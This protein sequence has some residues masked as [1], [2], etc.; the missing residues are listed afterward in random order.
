MIANLDSENITI[1]MSAPN[2][3]GIL[4]PE[5][6]EDASE[7]ILMLVMPIMLNN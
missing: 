6:K 7:D 1:E 2:R 3:A 5:G 4:L